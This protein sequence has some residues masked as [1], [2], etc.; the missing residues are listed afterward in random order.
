MVLGRP[1]IGYR[2]IAIIGRRAWETE[3]CRLRLPHSR[4]NMLKPENSFSPVWLFRAWKFGKLSSVRN[5][6]LSERAQCAALQGY[7]GHRA[8]LDRRFQGQGFDRKVLG[9]EPQNRNRKHREKPTGREQV[10]MCQY[11]QCRDCDAWRRDTAGLECMDQVRPNREFWRR[12]YPR[13]AQCCNQ[14]GTEIQGPAGE[15]GNVERQ[16]EDRFATGLRRLDG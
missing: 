10:L 1:T 2:C 5:E 7:G 11:R 9:P 14:R 6:Q 8:R 3:S 4:S 12:Q 15:S 16:A 13:L